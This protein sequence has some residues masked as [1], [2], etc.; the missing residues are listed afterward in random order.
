MILRFHLLQT[1]GEKSETYCVQ[2][3]SFVDHFFAQTRGFA[4]VH[5]KQGYEVDQLLKLTLLTNCQIAFVDVG[6]Y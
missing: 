1:I 6:M 2:R 4:V 5:V 3:Q